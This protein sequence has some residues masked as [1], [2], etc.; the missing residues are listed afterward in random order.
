MDT[1]HWTHEYLREPVEVHLHLRATVVPLLAKF[2]SWR[3][4]T[5]A[6]EVIMPL[7]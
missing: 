2:L 6:Y 7:T 5:R 4:Q 1:S 3:V